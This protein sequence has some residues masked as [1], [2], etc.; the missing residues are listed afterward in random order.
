MRP[1]RGSEGRVK[2]AS[3]RHLRGAFADGKPGDGHLVW[4]AKQN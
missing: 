1:V 2:E 3:H 4:E